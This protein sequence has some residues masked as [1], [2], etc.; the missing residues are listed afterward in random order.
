[1]VDPTAQPDDLDYRDIR[2]GLRDRIAL[3]QGILDDTQA[4]F[5]AERAKRELEHK[6]TVDG[7][8]GTLTNYR[9][10]LELEESFVRTMTKQGSKV[11]PDQTHAVQGAL[12]PARKPPLGDF[13][14]SE[15]ARHPMLN[16]EGLRLAAEIAG[17]FPPNGGGRVI[18]ATI[19]NLIRAQRVAVDADGK[20]TAR[21]SEKAFL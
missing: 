9:N 14:I 18:H 10:M 16:K 4:K 20:Y 12:S 21:E 6:K 3:L 5:E 15:L 13:L 11:G 1:M 19:M 7:L 17:Y 8:K 2:E